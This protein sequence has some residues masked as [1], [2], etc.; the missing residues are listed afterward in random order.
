MGGGAHWMQ[1]GLRSQPG[2]KAA[3]EVVEA[4]VSGKPGQGPARA[5]AGVGE[6]RPRGLSCGT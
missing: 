4:R 6:V 1:G 3:L 5:E 2:P